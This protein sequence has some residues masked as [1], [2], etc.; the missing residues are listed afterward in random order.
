MRDALNGLDWTL[1]FC[2][3]EGTL[4]GFRPCSIDFTHRACFFFDSLTF[5]KWRRPIIATCGVL[6]HRWH[7]LDS[8]CRYSRSDPQNRRQKKKKKPTQ[9]SFCSFSF[10]F[11]SSTMSRATRHDAPC[12]ASEFLADVHLF[13]SQSTHLITRL[14]KTHTQTQNNKK[15]KT[16]RQP[17]TEIKLQYFYP[18]HMC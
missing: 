14:N 5:Q 10:H 9:V 1:A 8:F 13:H 12:R 7:S 2:G 6:P 3:G 17:P 11:L 18:L 15:R 4:S 16:I